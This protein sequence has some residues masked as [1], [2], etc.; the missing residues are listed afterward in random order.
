MN[1]QKI[2]DKVLSPLEDIVQAKDIWKSFKTGDHFTTVLKKVSVN[3]KQGQFVIL[4]GPSGCGKSTLLNTLMGLEHPDSGDIVFMGMKIWTLNSDDRAVIRKASIGT[5]YQQQNW[6]KSLDVLS[7]VAL[8]GNLLG[9]SKEEARRKAQEQLEVVGMNHRANYKP[10]ELSSGEQQRISLARALMGNP[11]ILIADEPT[12]NLDI[13][14]GIKVM[15]IFK[16]LAQEGKT[17]LMVTHN[18]ESLDFADRILFMIDGHIRKDIMVKDGDIN[19]TKKRITKDLESFIQEVDTNEDSSKQS[20]PPPKVYH[21]SL[22]AKKISTLFESIWYNIVFTICMFLLLIL[23]VPG[24]ILQKLIFKKSNLSSKASNFVMN[25]FNRLE[26]KK[27]NIKKSISNW[28]LG[29]ISLGHL[30]EKKSRTLIT[31]LG[32]GIGIGFITFLLSLGYGVENLVINEMAEIEEM[33]QIL[34]DPITSS[35]IVLDSERYSLI[36]GVNGVSEIY[37]IISIAT[38]ISYS[39]SQTD[40]V[41]YGVDDKYLEVSKMVF[42]DG[43]NFKSN[44]NEIVLGDEI[45]KMLAVNPEEIIGKKVTLDFVLIGKEIQQT[46]V[47][48]DISGVNDSKLEYVVKGVVADTSGPVLYFPLDH[49]KK[50]GIENYSE[51]LVVLDSGSNMLSVRKEIETFGMKT[52]SVMDTVSEVEKIFGY[53]RIGLVVLGTVAFVIAVLGMVN[54]LTVSLME[55]TREVGLLKTIG[56]RSTEVRRLFITEAMM[57]S[58]SGG[59]TGLLIGGFCGALV[60]A[61]LTL[62]SLSRGGDVLIITKIPLMLIVSIIFF[63]VII[64][65]ITGLY[66]SRRAEKMSALDALRYE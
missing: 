35:Q 49:S 18:I 14:A 7:N 43:E 50:L 8:V 20:A 59:I 53:L 46:D 52:S 58:F 44:E 10:Y 15:N 32:M 66:P 64:G 48:K 17:I 3:I 34:V 57:I 11:S 13:K 26:K 5:I 31:I 54:T 41:A 51:L 30:M 12:G 42:V 39:G 21:E 22:G 28:D 1:A 63:S 16:K 65:F 47:K 24:Y 60:S 29:E 40:V 45:L 33:K 55:R 4:F 23:F 6:I 25:V 9:Y 56:M 36:E 61:I 62:I 19:D 27:K 38:T 37:P 2:P